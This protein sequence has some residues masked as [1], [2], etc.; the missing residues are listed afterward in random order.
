M[1]GFV[2]LNRKEC[3]GI[4]GGKDPAMAKLIEVV[5]YLFGMLVRTVRDLWGIGSTTKG[6]KFY[7]AGN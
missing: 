6:Y 7:I 5:G 1:K 4:V 3:V 2:Q